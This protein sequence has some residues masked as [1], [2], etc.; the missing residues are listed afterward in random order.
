MVPEVPT[1]GRIDAPGVAQAPLDYVQ[2][3]WRKSRPPVAPAQHEVATPARLIGLTGK[4]RS[5]KDT[6]AGFL[7]G[8]KLAFAAPLKRGLQIMLQLNDE[9]VN[10]DLKEVTLDWLGKSP[11]QLLQTLGT[12]WGRNLVHPD[13][14]LLVAKQ[15]IEKYL[16]MGLDVV[17]TDVRF[18]NEADL[19]RSL[20][21][22]VW[23][24]VRPDAQA[25]NAHASEAGVWFHP[26]KDYLIYNNGTLEEL[27]ALAL[28]TFDN[29]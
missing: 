18:D 12:D 19:I 6:V 8:Q 11:R 27:Q 28:E 14:W 5:G 3:D 4:A 13:L 9:H 1:Q 17:I 7:P 26:G 15:K 25:V 29:D 2:A 21:G 23:H 22:Q 24:I 20:G 16:S 10:G